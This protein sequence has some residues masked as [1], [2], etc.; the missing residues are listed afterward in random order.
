MLF[1]PVT[2]EPVSHSLADEC[3]KEWNHYLGPCNRPFGRQS[4]ALALRDVGPISIAVSASTVSTTCG[5]FDR[6]EV[7]E[8]ARLCSKPGYA[9]ATR[10]CLR[11]WR[12]VGTLDWA[13]KYW[14]IV[15][16]VSYSEIGRHDGNVYRFDGWR[17]FTKVRGGTAGG[18]RCGKKQYKAKVL[19]TY[20]INP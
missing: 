18:A 3:L 7:V 5:G 17:R 8:L 2:F 1:P 10:V 11:L 14:P 15:A 12:E 13:V 16:A 20:H 6:K 4:F 9:W 19:W